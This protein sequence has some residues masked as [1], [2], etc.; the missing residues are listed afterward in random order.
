MRAIVFYQHGGPDVLQYREDIP[1][2]QPGPGEVLVQVCYAAL[3]R[4]DDFVRTGWRGLNLTFPH[5]LGSDFS[6][7][8][9]AL[10]PEGN[11]LERRAACGGESDPLVWRVSAVH[12]GAAQPL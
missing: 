12:R 1:V 9:V 11:R 2:V 8:I 10:G 6:G 4:L 5:I 3:N 7:T